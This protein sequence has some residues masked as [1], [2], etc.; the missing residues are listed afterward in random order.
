MGS[1][2]P[3]ELEEAHRIQPPFKAP[4][5][6]MLLPYEL[7]RSIRWLLTTSSSLP[8]QRVAAVDALDIHMNRHVAHCDRHKEHG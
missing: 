1:V 6:Y 4:H 5:D 3:E 7:A 8:E 2:T